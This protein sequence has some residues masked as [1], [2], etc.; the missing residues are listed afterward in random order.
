MLRHSYGVPSV[1]GEASFFTN[2][3]EER[4]LKHP[5]HNRREAEAYVAALED[6]FSD[7]VPPIA[8]KY[9]TG[10]VEPF[11]TV[12]EEERM[13]PEALAWHEN[14]ERARELMEQGDTQALQEALDLFTLSARSFP[15]SFVAR[16]CHRLRAD[17]LEVL[18]RA[19]E[20]EMERRRVQ[21]FYIP[22]EATDPN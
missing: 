12:Q 16:D 20:G 4:R 5:D 21:E 22:V 18:G 3:D 19:D 14:F 17:I 15:D 10:R 11:E 2:P 7:P 9:S 1:I 6:F 8:E 13:S